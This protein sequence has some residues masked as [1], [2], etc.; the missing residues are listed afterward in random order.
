MQQ[1]T[2]TI[3]VAL[4]FLAGCAVGGASSQIVASSANAQ[5][6]VVP[7]ATSNQV[8]RWDYLCLKFDHD[9]SITEEAKDAGREGWEMITVLPREEHG[10]PNVWCFKRPL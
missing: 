10:S 2:R 9:E 6:P 1:L 4:T 8:Q 5:A 7:P 3:L